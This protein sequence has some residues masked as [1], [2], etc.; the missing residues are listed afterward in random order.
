MLY[1]NIAFYRVLRWDVRN[2]T[3]NTGYRITLTK[4]TPTLDIERV[5]YYLTDAVQGAK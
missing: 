5:K 4:F 3:A 1:H 2:R